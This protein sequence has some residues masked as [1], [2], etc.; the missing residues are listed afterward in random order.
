[1]DHE[2]KIKIEN[3]LFPLARLAVEPWD[4]FPWHLDRSNSCDSWKIHSSP[5]ASD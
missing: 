4:K 2:L 3:N 5:G 1:M